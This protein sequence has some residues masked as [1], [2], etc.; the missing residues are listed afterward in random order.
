MRKFRENDYVIWQRKK[1]CQVI[2]RLPPKAGPLF[3]GGKPPPG[4]HLD[5]K[6]YG[7]TKADWAEL[8]DDVARFLLL[9]LDEETEFE[10][11]G[12]D[13]LGPVNAM[14]L[15]AMM[16]RKDGEG[17]QERAEGRASG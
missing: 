7:L 17:G 11:E 15:I 13:L 4:A 1:L 2:K 14:E 9:D 3:G 16:A 10:A 12:Y 8:R 5:I 6:P